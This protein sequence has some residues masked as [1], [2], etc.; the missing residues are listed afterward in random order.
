M[1]GRFYDLVHGLDGIVGKQSTPKTRYSVFVESWQERAH[2]ADTPAIPGGPDFIGCLY[3]FLPDERERQETVKYWIG[4]YAAMEAKNGNDVMFIVS[5]GKCCG[6]EC[7]SGHYEE[8]LE[9]AVETELTLH[10]R[11]PED[12]SGTYV[13]FIERKKF[14][15]FFKKKR[16]E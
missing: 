9:S 2:R 4:A 12:I 8:P 6:A 7:C 5:S 16:R 10:D 13:Y 14:K 15:K 11:F 1:E 3:V